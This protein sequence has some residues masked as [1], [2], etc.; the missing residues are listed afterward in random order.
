M[1]ENRPKLGY[2]NVHWNKIDRKSRRKVSSQTLEEE[3]LEE[4]IPIRSM[5]EDMID[6]I[7]LKALSDTFCPPHLTSNDKSVILLTSPKNNGEKNE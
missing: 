7:Q 4:A 3:D 6:R 1:S 5:E 2:S